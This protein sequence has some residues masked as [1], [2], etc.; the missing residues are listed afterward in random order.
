ME[1]IVQ[2]RPA[3]SRW[4]EEYKDEFEAFMKEKVG[5]KIK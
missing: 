2:R 5:Q 3:L 1:D 4:S